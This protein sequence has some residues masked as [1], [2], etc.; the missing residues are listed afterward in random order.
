MS[1]AFNKHKNKDTNIPS[2]QD[3]LAAIEPKD[4]EE[5]QHILN[6]HEYTREICSMILILLYGEKHKHHWSHWKTKIK[7]E[8]ETMMDDFKRYHRT[9]VEW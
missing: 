5:F 8:S 4:I 2:V 1:Y 6:P 7:N 9:P 3:A